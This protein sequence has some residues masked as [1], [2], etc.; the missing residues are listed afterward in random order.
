MSYQK[1]RETH[2]NLY[3]GVNEKTSKYNL[4]N[5]QVSDL[6]NMDFN[7]PNALSKRPGFTQMA[8]FSGPINNIFEFERLAGASYLMVSSDDGLY[9]RDG[10]TFASVITG[11]TSGQAFDM[12]AFTDQL[13]A[14]NGETFIY[15]TGDTL[16]PHQLAPTNNASRSFAG[17]TT[18]P[19]NFLGVTN[20]S[21]SE[22]SM[23]I[24]GKYAVLD[25]VGNLSPFKFLETGLSPKNPLLSQPYGSNT[26]AISG[27]TTNGI[28]GAT[29]FAIYLYLY[30]TNGGF[31]PAGIAGGSD[32]SGFA[33]NIPFDAYRFITFLP[34][35]TITFAVANADFNFPEIYNINPGYT[36]PPFAFGESYTPKYIENFQERLLLSGFSTSPSVVFF[37]DIGNGNFVE[38]QNFFEVRT[39]DGDRITGT[40]TYRNEALI[41]KRN[42][43]HRLIGNSPDNY[44]LIEISTEYGCLSNQAIVEF[45]DKLAFLDERGVVMYN[46]SNY[47]IM[48]NTIELT[49]RRMNIDAAIDQAVAVHLDFRNQIWFG[50]PVDGSEVNNLTIV[51]DYLLNAWTFFDGFDAGAF[52]MARNELDRDYLWFGGQS[53]VLS[54]FSPSFYGDNGSGITCVV[55]TKFDAPDG[56]NIQNMF[57][58]LF[59][60]VNTPTGT[61]GTI[62]VEV[63]ADYN[64]A[65]V[66]QTFAV[67]QNQFQ[68]RTDF[69]VQG[70]SVAFKMTHNS[71]SL[72]LEMYGYTVQRRYLRDV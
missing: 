27:F 64:N 37:S 67:Y 12:L 4:Q 14:A 10:T 8:Q 3:G 19:L 28:A 9:Y 43:F 35:S 23:L 63:F 34:T 61:T 47:E 18:A 45:Q 30:D 21:A 53:G 7:V 15:W 41:F 31:D 26:F 57:R 22:N 48:T 56:Q 52:A 55:E 46:G 16:Y 17:S 25:D 6:R 32:D 68:T 36:G 71:P 24:S 11:L 13:W 29:A 51:Y 72:P 42:S 49:L 59:V 2:Y 40:K 66:Q 70:K 62:D 44:Q 1:R 20:T 50:I 65:L 60:D 5:Q 33:R 54:Y 69:G 38:P 58:R 39:N